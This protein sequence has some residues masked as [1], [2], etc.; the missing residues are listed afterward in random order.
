MPELPEVQRVRQTLARHL[1]GRTVINV[2]VNRA[3]IITG[4]ST[5][6]ALLQGQ[7]IHTL[8]R[9]GKQL[10]LCTSNPQAS[11]TDGKA[12]MDSPC[13]CVHLGMTGS[14]RHHPPKSQ[15]A[16]GDMRDTPDP[17]TAKHVHIVWTLDDGSHLTFTDPRR[18]GG[19]WTFP[20]FQSLLHQRWHTLGQ[21]ALTITPKQLYAKL[22]KTK[23]PIKA[24]L[25]DQVTVAGLGNIY[26]DEA[27]FDVAIHP[28]TPGSSI[29]QE[30]VSGLVRAFKAILKRAIA[31]GG[32]TIRSY[33]D[34]EGNSG[35]F[36][37]TLK[38]YGRAGLPCVTCKHVLIS[39]TVIGRTTTLCQYCQRGFDLA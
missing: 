34:G 11:N 3:D 9:H 30:A 37:K 24:A 39:T 8:E 31:S 17:L 25:L 29:T 10:A 13:L 1:L 22:A 23:R 15:P 19:L 7:T 36:Q 5:S 20:N 27:L 32:S 21:D 6:A 33:T 4:Q 12:S 28:M 14:L 2:Q 38:V 16:S 18:F 35:T 26:V